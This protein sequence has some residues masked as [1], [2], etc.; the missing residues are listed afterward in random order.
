MSTYV[1]K[2]FLLKVA[3]IICFAAVQIP[4]TWGFAK[5]LLMLALLSALIS[6]GLALHGRE[7]LSIRGLNYWDEV[8]MF[9]AIAMGAR[10]LG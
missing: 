2:R 3:L 10:L 6:A 8:I 1:L 7:R 9:M 5:A 4:T